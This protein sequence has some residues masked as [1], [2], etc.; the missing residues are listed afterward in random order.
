MKN[1]TLIGALCLAISAPSATAEWFEATGQAVIEQGDM[2]SARQAAMQDA[3][4]RAALVAGASVNSSLQVVNGVLQSEQFDIESSGEIKQLQLMSE[5]QS[6]N[7][8][9]V[10]VRVDIEVQGNGCEGNTYRKPL[11]LSQIQLQARQDAIHGQL[12][13]LG[14]DSTTV[15]EK[16]LRDYAPAAR[17]QQLEHTLETQQLVY[18][19]TDQLFSQGK[20]YVLLG[21]ITDLSLGQTNSMFWQAEEKERYF[22]IDISLFDLFEQSIVYQ[23]EYRTSASWQLSNKALLQSHSQAFWQAPYGQKIDQVLQAIAED[24]QQHLQCKPLLSSINQT[25]NNQIVLQ[26]GKA[27]GLQ[28]GDS[29]QVNLLQRHPTS[30][31][32][33][34]VVQDPLT[35]SITE[36]TEQHAWATSPNATLI[37]HVRQGDIVSVRKS[38]GF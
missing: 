19:E 37:Q 22:A 31:G 24:V 4:K 11:L 7:M 26:L 12:F 27:N 35:L 16:H 9:T 8:L 13:N 15:L 5:S 10:T 28:I 2:S 33:K 17:A 32:I 23:Q 29:V 14:V 30:P 21:K 6:G 34:R 36:V 3:V 20:Q 38:S 25:E 1:L 18:P